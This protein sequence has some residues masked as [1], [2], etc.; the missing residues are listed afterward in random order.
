[1]DDKRT[2]LDLLYFRFRFPFVLVKRRLFLVV[3]VTRS[4][5]AARAR[6]GTAFSILLELPD[7][8]DE[9]FNSSLF[10]QDLLDVS[11]VSL[12]LDRRAES[13]RD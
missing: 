2:P 3:D 5:L 8:V 4:P 7:V 13:K 10:R 12:L 6:E 11:F 9:L 1:M